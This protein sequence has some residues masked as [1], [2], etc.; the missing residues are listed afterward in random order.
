VQKPILALVAVA[1]SALALAG[2]SGTTSS[3]P[4]N[5]KVDVVA[6]TDV[7]GAIA[8]EV[9]GPYVSVTSMIAS[10]SQDPHEFQPSAS[11]QLLVQRAGLLI[12]NGGGYDPF[13]DGIVSSAGAKAPVIVAAKLSPEYPADGDLA[14]HTDDDDHAHDHLAG[15]NEHVFYDVSVMAKVADEIAVRLGKIDPAH[16]SA[17]T[18]H[19]K[20]FGAGV[21]KIEAELARLKTAHEGAGVFVTEPLPLY[22]TDAA[23]LDNKT[24]N[25]FSEAVEGGQDVPPAT[26][27]S[28]LALIS[29]HDVA[30][31]ITNAQAAG[32][33]T[34]QVEQT[35]K[36]AGVPVLKFSELLPA[37]KTYLTWMQS[38]VAALTKAL[39]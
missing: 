39:G 4:T 14:A 16:A 3:A 38:N 27:L 20:T 7:Y 11:D 37:G 17:F 6:T 34:T 22:L 9:G 31:V 26:L 29:H 8:A 2:C 5:G 21:E 19:A 1:A 24:P 25:A 23:G 32:A 30:V 10:I 15:F 12:E 36:D 33:E 13:L 35:A 28:A 18:A